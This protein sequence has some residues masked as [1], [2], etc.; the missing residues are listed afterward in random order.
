MKRTL[1]LFD[2]ETTGLTK[3]G[4]SDVEE[5]PYITEIFCLKVEQDGKDFEV[6]DEFESLFKVPVPLD[7][8]ITKITGLTDADLVNQPTFEQSFQTLASFFTGVD[9]MVAHNLAFDRTMLA[10]EIVRIKRLLNFPWPREHICTVEKTI[11]IEQRRLSLTK[12]HDH[13]FDEEFP[14][15]HR[16]KNDVMPMYRC[17]KELVKRG[18]IK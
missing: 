1:V 4:A 16:A 12:L 5:Q 3:P 13:L 17:Y 10:N 6:I 18:I 14:N 7:A 8:T 2:T 11:N 9:A 15:A